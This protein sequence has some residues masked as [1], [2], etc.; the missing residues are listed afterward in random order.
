MSFFRAAF[1]AYL[2]FSLSPSDKLYPFCSE[3]V[4]AYR[5]PA[6]FENALAVRCVVLIFCQ[7]SIAPFRVWVVQPMRLPLSSITT[8]EGQ[9]NRKS[10]K[11]A[12][13]FLNDT[14]FD[15]LNLTVRRISGDDR[16][17]DG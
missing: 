7:I 15:K 17:I 3:G 10:P 4:S 6:A 2:S 12:K 14:G 11:E 1:R 16:W 9:N 5:V 8:T 13:T